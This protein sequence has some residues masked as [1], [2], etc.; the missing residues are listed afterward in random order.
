MG[1]SESETE[2]QPTCNAASRSSPT[3]IAWTATH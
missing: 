2:N 3:C 1:D